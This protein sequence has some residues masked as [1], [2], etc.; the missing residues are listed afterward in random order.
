ME[1][2]ERGLPYP[3]V[4]DREMIVRYG[5]SG[6][7]ATVLARPP[8]DAPSF[9]L[10]LRRT[11]L[12]WVFDRECHNDVLGVAACLA[13]LEPA[14]VDELALVAETY[15]RERSL[16]QP[17]VW[18]VECAPLSLHRGDAGVCVAKLQTMLFHAAETD[19]EI[20]GRFGPITEQALIAFQAARGLA[21]DGI[22][23]PDTWSALV[24]VLTLPDGA[25]PASTASMDVTMTATGSEFIMGPVRADVLVTNTGTEPL[26]TLV[27]ADDGSGQALCLHSRITGPDHLVGNFD[28][29]LDPGDQWMYG[30]DGQN[31][32]TIEY[33]VDV[34]ATTS[35]GASVSATDTIR[36][37]GAWPVAIT[38][39][40]STASVT[41]G[42]IVQWVIDVTNV[43][44]FA[45]GF[46]ELQVAVNYPEKPSPYEFDQL[47]L[48]DIAGADGNDSLDPGETWTWNYSAPVTVD[49]S[50]LAGSIGVV[51]VSGVGFGFVSDPIA[52]AGGAA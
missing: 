38:A 6:A 32:G 45:L 33:W 48:P 40:T 50:W 2:I 1:A 47:G 42:D 21:A 20:D 12:G 14:V 8:T 51:V 36:Y 13:D 43:A 37:Q 49:G 10:L 46:Q 18:E 31:R 23:G 4:A 41:S 44:D 28:E 22:A 19:L 52:V 27:V 17:G 25:A 15:P 35:T 30:C 39:A 24:A 9:V 7:W 3:G 16:I 34:S 29:V 11:A 5:C 26:R